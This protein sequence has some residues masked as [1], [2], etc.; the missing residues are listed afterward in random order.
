MAAG[1]PSCAHHAN[2]LWMAVTTAG[3]GMVEP[4]EAGGGT[5][6]QRALGVP[7]V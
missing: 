1:R 6:A 3:E 5:A 7:A 2:P 4:R